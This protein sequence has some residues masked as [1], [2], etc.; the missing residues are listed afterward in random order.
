M[1]IFTNNGEMINRASTG[2][3][4]KYR[5]WWEIPVPYRL[6]TH[7]GNTIFTRNDTFDESSLNLFHL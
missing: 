4:L 2:W 3:S 6:L 7:E 5:Q 1:E